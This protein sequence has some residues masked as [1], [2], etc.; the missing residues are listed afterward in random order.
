MK[1][2]MCIFITIEIHI[3]ILFTTLESPLQE[4]NCHIRG[5]QSLC[6]SLC[7]DALIFSEHTFVLCIFILSHIF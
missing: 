2:K 7:I 3:S 6:Q 5:S 4:Y 1:K